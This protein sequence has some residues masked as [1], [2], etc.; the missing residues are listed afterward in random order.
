VLFLAAVRG[1]GLAEAV[2]ALSFA[3]CVYVYGVRGVCGDSGL[4]RLKSLLGVIDG[5]KVHDRLGAVGF[6]CRGRRVGGHEGIYGTSADGIVRLHVADFGRLRVR[7]QLARHHL[8]HCDANCLGAMARS[9]SRA[10]AVIKHLW[11]TQ[12]FYQRMPPSQRSCV[13]WAW[14]AF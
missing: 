7:E 8:E 5:G 2:T 6:L 9:V 1:R 10:R 13:L 4:E 14:M 12:A 3:V 11:G